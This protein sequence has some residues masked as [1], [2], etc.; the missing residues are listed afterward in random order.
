[1]RARA[2]RQVGSEFSDRPA[3]CRALHRAG[4]DAAIAGRCVANLPFYW[5][6][7]PV[8]RKAFELQGIDPDRVTDDG[9][10]A[11]PW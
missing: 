5:R 9:R 6:A 8:Y 4:R 1:V 7:W 2:P 10:V 11:Q 3:R